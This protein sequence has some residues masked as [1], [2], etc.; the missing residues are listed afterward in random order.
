[1]TTNRVVW[2]SSLINT[3][4][5]LEIKFDKSYLTKGQI[6]G[7]VKGIPVNISYQLHI[8]TAWSIRS[9]LIQVES[10][11]S[12]NLSFYKN[13]NNEWVDINRKLLSDFTGCQ[14]IDISLTPFTN[15]L[16]IN[17]LKLAQG[18]SEE[19]KLIYFNLPMPEYKPVRQRYTNLGRGSYKY[20][21]LETGFTSI[22]E[23]DEK[24]IV[25]NYPGIWQRIY[26][27]QTD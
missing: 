7:E 8:D 13:E 3:I 14:D 9:V 11:S 2:K 22:L 20:E 19:I 23:V 26:P 27:P 24:G 25:I 12:F 4:E 16:P 10:D 18:Q 6:T 17:R 15:T 21:N 1:M 5:Y